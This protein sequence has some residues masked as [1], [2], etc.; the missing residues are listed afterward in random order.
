VTRQRAAILVATLIR[1]EA[2]FADDVA[3]IV[4]ANGIESAVIGSADYAAAADAPNLS[5]VDRLS[6]HAPHLRSWLRG[7]VRSG[8]AVH[9]DP[10]TWSADDKL[11]QGV[12][13]GRLGINVPRTVLLADARLPSFANSAV[14]CGVS[15]ST[16]GDVLDHIGLPA[17]LK[18][19]QGFSG[20]SVRRV[21]T[22][23][24]AV[25]AYQWS[26]EPMIL[27]EAIAW[28]DYLRVMVIGHASKVMRYQFQ[29]RSPLEPPSGRDYSGSALLV[30]RAGSYLRICSG[31]IPV[32]T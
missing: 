21:K 31:C 14:P 27:Q 28:D 4:H 17:C 24:E 12:M 8:A 20:H 32:I 1:E 3:A 29:H 26:D 5:V 10:F 15:D 6:H 2:E 9:P 16:W 7:L 30:N 18:S 25:N 11:S 19:V 22:A 13:A 23:A